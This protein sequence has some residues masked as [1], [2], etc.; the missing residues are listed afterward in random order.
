MEATATPARRWPPSPVS[1]SVT[2]SNALRGPAR[3]ARLASWRRMSGSGATTLWAT[4]LRAMT[5]PSSSTARALTDVVPTSTP[6][7][8]ARGGRT[9]EADT[10]VMITSLWTT[11]AAEGEDRTNDTLPAE[12]PGD[13]GRERP[14]A[15]PAAPAGGSR[16]RFVARPAHICG[17]TTPPSWRNGWPPRGPPSSSW[18][19]TSAGPSSTSSRSSPCAAAGVTPPTSTC[20]PPPPPACPCCGPPAATPTRWPSW[21]WPCS[22]PPPAASS[23]RTATCGRAR[24]TATGRSPTSATGPG[25][26]PARPSAWWASGPSGARSGGA[27]AASAWTSSPMTPTHPTPRARSTTC[28]RGPTSSR[29][30]LR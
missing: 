17:S 12:G 16:A 8:T 3:H 1:C 19:A 29:S 13:R 10:R 22:S 23:R 18:R 7:V 2:C 4:L 20:P 5:V 28:W 27:C 24:S 26:W 25:S 15:R 11:P 30:T 9:H 14:R 6:T 21:P